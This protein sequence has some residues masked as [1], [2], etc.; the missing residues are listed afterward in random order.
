MCI[1]RSSCTPSTYLCTS[2]MLVHTKISSILHAVAHSAFTWLRQDLHCWLHQRSRFCLYPRYC[3]LRFHLEVTAWQIRPH[4]PLTAVQ[5]FPKIAQECTPDVMSR[6][7]Y[8]IRQI[9][10][11]YVKR[12]IVNMTKYIY[13]LHKTCYCTWP[14]WTNI[15]NHICTMGKVHSMFRCHCYAFSKLQECM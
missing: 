9:P 14:P 4:F 6:F 13:T 10:L 3:S 2:Q 7:N 11:P 1:C 5:K 8:S 12:S 15:R